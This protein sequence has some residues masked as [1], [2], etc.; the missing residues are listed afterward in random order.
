[1][2]LANAG[3]GQMFRFWLAS[4]PAWRRLAGLRSAADTARLRAGSRDVLLDGLQ[5]RARERRGNRFGALATG[6]CPELYNSFRPGS[7]RLAD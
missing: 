7:A 3:L 4:R 2:S 1:M 6:A 5:G